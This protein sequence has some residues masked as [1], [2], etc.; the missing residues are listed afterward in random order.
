[1]IEYLKNKKWLI[2][3]VCDWC[4]GGILFIWKPVPWKPH[5]NY[6]DW[7]FDADGLRC[8]RTPWFMLYLE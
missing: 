6:R 2:D 7:G 4:I 8:I 1:M 5:Y 3:E